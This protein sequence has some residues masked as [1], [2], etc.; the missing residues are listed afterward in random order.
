MDIEKWKSV[1]VPIEV[2]QGI[3]AI[4]QHEKRTISGQLRV[5]YE[6]FCESEK[7]KVNL[8]GNGNKSPKR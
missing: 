2:Y 5:M 4:A 8:N 3:K 1:L 7:I 6:K